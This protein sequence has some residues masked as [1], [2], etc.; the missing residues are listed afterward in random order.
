M[1]VLLS[2]RHIHP[3]KYKAFLSILSLGV[4]PAS[5]A[6]MVLPAAAPGTT[7]QLVSASQ[8]DS[9]NVNLSAL[10]S[11]IEAALDQG[12]VSAI[13]VTMTGAASESASLTAFGSANPASYSVGSTVDVVTSNTYLASLT[14]VSSAGVQNPEG[15]VLFVKNKVSG[16]EVL[17]A[18]GVSAEGANVESSLDNAA[19]F[20]VSPDVEASTSDSGSFTQVEGQVINFTFEA[21][22]ELEVTKPF[23]AAGTADIPYFVST[24]AAAILRRDTMYDTYV[25][26]A[27]PEPSSVGFMALSLLAL[28]AR[29][30]A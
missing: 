11:N 22:G 4:L 23:P 28:G 9:A 6:V 30:R 27:V 13:P 18:L 16:V 17:S 19:F 14:V 15:D 25:L 24:D 10:E 29:R 26:V 1:H 5:A 3:M 8:L 21:E 2:N 7:W 20:L 12:G